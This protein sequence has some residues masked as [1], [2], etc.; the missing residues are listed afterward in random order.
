MLKPK[1]EES[2]KMNTTQERPEEAAGADHR[3]QIKGPQPS[4]KT[5]HR[6]GTGDYRTG[7]QE[8]TETTRPSSRH[9]KNGEGKKIES[10]SLSVY[11]A[12]NRIEALFEELDV[13]TGEY[14]RKSEVFEAQL[15]GAPK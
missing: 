6:A 14:E 3:R 2:Q 12:R 10:L 7:E 13:A 9:R 15:G 8:S 1:I 4:Q 11:N 5:D